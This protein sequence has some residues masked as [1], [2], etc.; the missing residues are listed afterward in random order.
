M[1]GA[2]DLH[3]FRVCGGEGEEKGLLLGMERFLHIQGRLLQIAGGD[4]TDG[5]FSHCPD[6]G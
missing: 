3:G 5:D 4:L 1:I 2:G 6:V